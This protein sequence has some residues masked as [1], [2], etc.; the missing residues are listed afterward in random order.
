[1][2]INNKAFEK[3]TKA[4]LA[5]LIGNDTYRGNNSIV[6]QFYRMMGEGYKAAEEIS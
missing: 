5:V 1:M 6:E 3:W 2:K 4:D